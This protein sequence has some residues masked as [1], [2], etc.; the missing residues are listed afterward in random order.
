MMSLRYKVGPHGWDDLESSWRKILP[1]AGRFCLWSTV[2]RASF[3][4]T[5]VSRAGINMKEYDLEYHLHLF[6]VA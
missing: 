1:G 4:S 6:W 5:L 2:I 3:L